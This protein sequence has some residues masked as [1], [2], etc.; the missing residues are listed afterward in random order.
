[1]EPITI[2]AIVLVIIFVIYY[3][4]LEADYDSKLYKIDYIR[5]SMYMLV[6]A[7]YDYNIHCIVNYSEER[8]NYDEIMDVDEA[9][10]LN[11]V[12]WD[13]LVSKDVLV[14]LKPYLPE[15]PDMWIQKQMRKEKNNGYF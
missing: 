10:N 15:C 13:K 6:D 4:C 2:F 1:M 12:Y 3:I 14:K 9:F 11:T 5:I 8:I 7:I